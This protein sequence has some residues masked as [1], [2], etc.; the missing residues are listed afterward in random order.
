MAEA[1]GL[2]AI[3]A[4]RIVRSSKADQVR[5]LAECALG[6]A[7]SSGAGAYVTALRHVARPI[8]LAGW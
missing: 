1:P 4:E 6:L 2:L 5:Q 3:A 8:A 7:I